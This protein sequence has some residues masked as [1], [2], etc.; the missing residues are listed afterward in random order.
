MTKE[1]KEEAQKRR[2]AY[3]KEHGHSWIANRQCSWCGA[4]KSAE[5]RSVT[6]VASVPVE[7]NERHCIKGTP[8]GDTYYCECPVCV[9]ERRSSVHRVD[10]TR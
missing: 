8:M 10:Y 7:S 1:T 2:T 4:W 3:C 6:V 9:S 5:E